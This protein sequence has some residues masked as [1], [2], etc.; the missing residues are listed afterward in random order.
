MTQMQASPSNQVPYF[1]YTI[2]FRP[3]IETL[4]KHWKLI[5]SLVFV[6]AA[7][8]FTIGSIRPTQYTA[9]VDVSLLS[10]HSQVVFDEQFLTVPAD[11]Y[12]LYRDNSSRI[13]ALQALA[14]S[15]SL[16][17]GVFGQV[18]PQLEPDQRDF[19]AFRDAVKAEATGDLLRLQATWD[20]PD[21]AALI[22]NTWAQQYAAAANRSYVSTSSGS[23]DEANTS[24]GEAFEKYEAAQKQLEAFIAENDLDLVR[25]E[26]GELDT[27]LEELQEQKTNALR[28]ANSTEALSANRLANTTRDVLL[29]QMDLSVKREA[30][31]RARQLNDWYDRKINLER[32][33]I[34][35]EDLQEQL[36]KGN[37]SAAAAGGDSLALMFTRAGLFRQGG[38]PELLLNIDLNQLSESGADLTPADVQTLLA[39]VENGLTEANTEIERL[40]GEL[41]LGEKL[42]IPTEIPPDHE[43]FGL[44]AQ[45]VEA[46]LNVGV[47]LETDSIELEG[48][49][50]SQTL[51]R[52]SDRR[53][54][55]RSQLENLEARERELTR[56]RDTAWGLYTTLDNKAREVEA[57]FATGA[58]QVRLAMQALP[59]VEPDPRGRLLLSLIAA[60]VGGLI[61]V[62]YVFGRVYWEESAPGETSETRSSEP[63]EP[64]ASKP[65]VAKPA[66]GAPRQEPQPVGD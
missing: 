60:A 63:S 12:Q 41:F 7:A 50:L 61:G 52:L 31:D 53:Q 57:Q 2:D 24:A 46:I 16:L 3:Y 39:I 66:P 47:V 20:D 43:L 33:Q 59:P 35:L 26:I 55:L 17:T 29:D 38:I 23:L 6:A 19:K 58:P 65:E 27:L 51:D 21:I 36:K 28:L 15:S 4:V 54:V 48:K 18:S 25:R 8:A 37:T 49:P 13:E 34:R 10:V 5:I 62:V 11:E 1:D 30:E 42:E 9:E 64:E 44:M 14:E 32:L 45:Q 56:T 40:T 22:V